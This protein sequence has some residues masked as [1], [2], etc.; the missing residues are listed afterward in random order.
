M[1]QFKFIS[2]GLILISLVWISCE[3]SPELVEN[4]PPTAAFVYGP[5][6]ID[7]TT[8]VYFNASSSFD[9]QD[10]KILLRYS[11]DFEGDHNWTA[12]G[13]SFESNYRYSE[14]GTYEAGLKVI[15]THGWSGEIR[16]TIIIIDS[17]NLE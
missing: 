15:D 4:N 13:I 7:T 9:L 17:L 16:K 14:P 8:T 3:D 2:L 1:K 11:W 5:E 10:D 6:L 12:P